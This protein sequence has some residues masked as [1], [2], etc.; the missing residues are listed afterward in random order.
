MDKKSQWPWENRK[1]FYLKHF[2]SK[3]HINI[4]SL[5]LN[6]RITFEK[7]NLE[8]ALGDKIYILPFFS[9]PELNLKGK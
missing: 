5:V 8:F 3:H 6:W 4:L 9:K 2:H 7:P 1:D